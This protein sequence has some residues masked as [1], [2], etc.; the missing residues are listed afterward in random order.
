MET[1]TY[2]AELEAYKFVID[3]LNETRV[4]IFNLSKDENRL[5]NLITKKEAMFKKEISEEMNE[6]GKKKYSNE[7]MRDSELIRREAINPDYSGWEMQAVEI[8]DKKQEKLIELEYMKAQQKYWELVISI[9]KNPDESESLK[10]IAEAT[11][12][13]AKRK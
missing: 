9:I 4:A 5:N 13:L 10:R 12:E 8:N 2:T 11:Q 6:D 3:K 7:S 1:K